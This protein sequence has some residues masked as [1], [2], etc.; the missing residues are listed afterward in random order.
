MEEFQAHNP[1]RWSVVVVFVI[2]IALIGGIFFWAFFLNVGTVRVSSSDHFSLQVNS[3]TYECTPECEIELPVG[4][5]RF[6]ASR[7]GYYNEIFSK[8]VEMG[9]VE[10]EEVSFRLVPYL[11][12]LE[13]VSVLERSESGFGF[14]NTADGRDLISA[15]GELVVSF[16]SLLSPELHVG[17]KIVAVVDEGRLFIVDVEQKRRR[18][19]FDDSLE[20]VSAQVSDNGERV[21]IHV[22]SDEEPQMWVWRPQSAELMPSFDYFD[23]ASVVW[24]PGEDHKLV[25]VVE[26]VA[27]YEDQSGILDDLLSSVTEAEDRVAGLVVFNLDT[28]DFEVVNEFPLGSPTEIFRVQNRVFLAYTSGD[29]QELVVQE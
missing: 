25:L 7:E 23:P 2:I 3:S 1:S 13:D 27:L 10:T 20:V 21:L 19:L 26:D 11:D 16:E 5:H 24:Y 22:L 12:L 14:V 15:D 9:N 6:I 17:G 28:R 4:Q 18:R 8:L 29:Y